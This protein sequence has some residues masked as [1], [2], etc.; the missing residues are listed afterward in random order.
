MRS[1]PGRR[2]LLAYDLHPDGSATFREEVVPQF[3]P[4]GMAIDENGNL[5]LTRGRRLEV[6]SPSGEMLAQIPVPEPA[7]NATF[8]RG[9]TARIL[10]ITAGRS[11][12]RIEV[13]NAG[14]RA[15]R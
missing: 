2:A 9:K 6:Y 10:Y 5:Y 12:Y 14:Y 15:G 4:D 8:G 13:K 7:R 3:G 1:Y 11:L